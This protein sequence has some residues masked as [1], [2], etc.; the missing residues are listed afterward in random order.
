[1]STARPP[2]ADDSGTCITLAG[3]RQPAPAT[4]PRQ[5]RNAEAL[6]GRTADRCAIR[7]PPTRRFGGTAFALLLGGEGRNSPGLQPAVCGKLSVGRVGKTIIKSCDVPLQH[8]EGDTA[9]NRTGGVHSARLGLKPHGPKSIFV[10]R[11]PSLVEIGAGR[12]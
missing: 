12:E 9:M 3:V 4:W 1:M 2:V 6:R 7:F 8:T 11:P 5:P 10:S